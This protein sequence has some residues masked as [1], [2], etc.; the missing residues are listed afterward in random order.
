MHRMM[1]AR[2]AVDYPAPITCDYRLLHIWSQARQAV[3][4]IPHPGHLSGMPGFVPKYELRDPGT[5]AVGVAAGRASPTS[6]RAAGIPLLLADLTVE[7]EE[8]PG[9]EE[10]EEEGEE[11]EGEVGAAGAAA[12]GAAAGAAG[13]AVELQANYLGLA[14]ALLGG[15]AM[16]LARLLL[17]PVWQGVV[18]LRARWLKVA[19]CLAA[20]PSPTAR[21]PSHASPD[22]A[23]G[24]WGCPTHP[25]GE[26]EPLRSSRG[27]VVPTPPRVPA[28]ALL[29]RERPGWLR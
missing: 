7:V 3:E 9:E 12:A 19:P 1:R 15:V 4:T 14:C 6:S 2:Q 13:S 24:C 16:R 8:E 27:P 25:G 23:T 26:P 17:E 5:A 10:E 21:Q 22:E 29:H 18:W 20:P 11:E 28:C